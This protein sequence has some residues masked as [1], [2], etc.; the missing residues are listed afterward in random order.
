MYGP[1]L[2]APPIVGPL[3][4]TALSLIP[5]SIVPWSTW[6]AEHLETTVLAN[7]LDGRTVLGSGEESQSGGP[8]DT[9]RASAPVLR[10]DFVI[11]VALKESATAYDFRR[12]AEERVI[13]D[14]IG[15][16]PVVVFVDPQTRD[17]KV[18]LRRPAQALPDEGTPAELTFAIEGEVVIDSETGSE[19]DPTGGFAV[20]GPLRG[21]VLQQ[22]PYITSFIWAW[23]DFFP[24][25]SVYGR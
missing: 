25:T 5:A 11:G 1:S 18:Y 17:I 22:I 7:E 21:V 19:W 13:N 9:R 2:G 8:Y 14:R 3:E 15:K 6:L 20:S 4:G 23:H 24:H 12:A 16:H 10:D